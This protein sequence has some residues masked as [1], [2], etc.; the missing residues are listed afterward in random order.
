MTILNL[1]QLESF[2]T[3][4]QYGSFTAAAQRLGLRQSTVT[5][6]LQKLEKSVGRRLVLRDTHQLRLTSDG[7]ALLVYARS[8]LELNGKAAALFDESRLRGR[9]RFGASEDV[10]ASR[11]SGV[12]EDFIRLYPLVDLELTV[13][14]SAELYQMQEAGEL[15]LVLAKRLPCE[16]HGELLYREPLVW[17]A[18]DPDLLLARE[19][20]LPLIAF[21]PPSLTRRAAQAALDREKRAW[22][23]S[24]TCASLS[25]LTAAARAGMG[26]LVQPRSMAPMGLKEVAAGRLPELGDAEFVTVARRDADPALIKALNTLIRQLV[27]PQPP[28]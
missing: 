16:T 17:L 15:D 1:A 28:A 2:V 26:V 3:L 23:I 7:E 13:A 11:L 24:C 5:Q 6:H 8:M 25:G 18:R 14:L 10:V 21:P 22:R 27:I 4:Q 20:A 19:G 9:L 12:L